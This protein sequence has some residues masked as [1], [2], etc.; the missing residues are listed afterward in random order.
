MPFLVRTLPIVS[1]LLLCKAH[2][3]HLIENLLFQCPG[4]VPL[5]SILSVL[6]VYFSIYHPAIFPCSSLHQV[7][8]AGA[9]YQLAL[10]TGSP[11]LH[12]AH[13]LTSIVPY[14]SRKTM[15]QAVVEVALEHISC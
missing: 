11:L 5:Q 2:Q 15:W 6:M 7:L 1:P 10:S 3:L 13:V 4:Q 12:H 8:E 14:P 9:H